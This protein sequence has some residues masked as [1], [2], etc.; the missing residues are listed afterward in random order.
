V[1]QREKRSLGVGDVIRWRRNNKDLGLINADVGTVRQ[2]DARS[3]HVTINFRRAG[4]KAV[5]LREHRHWEHGYATTV[6]AG[7]GA[8][9]DNAIVNAESYRHNLINQKSFYVALSRA[10]FDTHIYTDDIREL[11]RRI[12]QRPGDKTSAIEGKKLNHAKLIDEHRVRNK[13]DRP[14]V[15]RMID[16]VNSQLQIELDT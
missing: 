6:Y 4:S 8:T 10:R 14:L 16:R 9:Y 1:Y 3:G 12:G 15:Q 13:T 2:I 7:Q 11:A 5:D